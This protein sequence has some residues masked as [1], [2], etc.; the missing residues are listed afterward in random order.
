MGRH[1]S[2]AFFFLRTLKYIMKEKPCLVFKYPFD[3]CPSSIS[4]CFV[5]VSK[6]HI[7]L[8][9]ATSN[10]MHLELDE[11]ISRP[12]F[13]DILLILIFHIIFCYTQFY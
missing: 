8:N 6:Y 10:E 7:V 13:S 11:S 1:R 12:G 9:S 2:G 4:L 5:L 3:F